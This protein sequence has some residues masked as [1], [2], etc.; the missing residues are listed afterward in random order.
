MRCFRSILTLFTSALIL[1]SCTSSKLVVDPDFSPSEV[2]PDSI[3]AVV[4]DYSGT[5]NS[6]KGKGRAIVSE[7]GNS[8]RVTIEFESDTL[9]SLLTIKNRIGI[10]GGQMLVDQDSILIYNKIDKFARKVS[11]TNGRLTSLNELASVNLLD[12]L[13][14]K[15]EENSIRRVYESESH[16]LLSFG[17]NGSA[18][19]SKEGGLITEV[20]Q[21]VNSGLPYSRIIYEGY[22]KAEGYT[23]PRKIT[24]FSADG[25]S[26]VLF[27]VRDLDVNPEELSLTI[28]IP[29][30]ISIQRL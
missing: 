2:A 17:N 21:P 7:P 15:L 14:F 3:A 9:F 25:E 12:L 13:N 28:D 30:E 22:S 8:D 24:I 29:D 11:V 5:L 16:Y 23:L 27:Q 20:N 10:E 26:K 4:P 1:A 19:V 6:A 18:L